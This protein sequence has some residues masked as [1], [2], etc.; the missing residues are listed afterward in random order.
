MRD[1]TIIHFF[2]FIVLAIAGAVAGWVARDRRATQ[3]HKA[4]KRMWQEELTRQ[5]KGQKRLAARNKNLMA[6]ISQ[7]Q[8]RQSRLKNS[9][10]ELSSAMRD[11]STRREELQRD[12]ESRDARI[13]TLTRDLRNWQERLP[14][15]VD[16]YRRR[17]REAVELATMLEEATTTVR[18]LEEQHFEAAEPPVSIEP[19][20]DTGPFTDGLEASNDEENEYVDEVDGEE[21]PVFLDES[22]M[23]E[24][25]ATADNQQ[26]HAAEIN[27]HQQAHAAEIDNRQHAHAAEIDNHQ[28]AHAAE[29]DDEQQAHAMEADGT[30]GPA[31]DDADERP[32]QRDDLKKIKGVGPAIEKTLNEMGIISYRQIA[33]M[34]DYDIDHV[35]RRLQGF[36]GRIHSEDWIGQARTL[37]DKS[38]LA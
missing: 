17:N 32:Q 6:Q 24:G 27:D 13:E 2:L 18:K 14:P 30:C 35:A 33:D 9:A 19:L 28:H 38:A 26:A 16:R 36:R 37:L 4:S 20:R 3:E 5:R 25:D 22:T 7:H 15:L 31:P 1:F 34:T 23:I 8:A 21:T 11:A 10:A 12:I 29:T